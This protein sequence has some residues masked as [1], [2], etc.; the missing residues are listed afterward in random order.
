MEEDEV[1]KVIVAPDPD[2]VPGWGGY[3][4]LLADGF[5]DAFI[6]VCM[7][8]GWNGYVAAYDYEKCIRIL[9]DKGAGSREEAEEYFQ[10]NVVGAWVGDMT[11]V[12]ISGMK[13]DHLIDSLIDTEEERGD[14]D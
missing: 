13:M 5:E 12:F 7:R 10:Y 3:E 9:I 4:I 6:G 14:D 11:P 1:V 8:F 2:T